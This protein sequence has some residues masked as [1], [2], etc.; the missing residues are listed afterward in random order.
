MA[1]NTKWRQ[2]ECACC[3]EIFTTQAR[4]VR[5]CPECREL[6]SI[7]GTKIRTNVNKGLIADTRKVQKY[8][9]E[10]GTSLS[11][12]KYKLMLFLGKGKKK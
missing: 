11:Y 3:G 8:N 7:D 5:Y 10:H 12:G 9:E 6:E 2:L 4:Y 1:K